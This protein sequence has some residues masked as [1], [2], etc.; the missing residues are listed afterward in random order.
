MKVIHMI[1]AGK[2]IARIEDGT[3]IRLVEPVGICP[4]N[5]GEWYNA[6]FYDIPHSDSFEERW[7][8][9]RNR[10]YFCYLKPELKL[11]AETV[12]KNPTPIMTETDADS[13]LDPLNE[14][15]HQIIRRLS[16]DK[17]ADDGLLVFTI[18]TDGA[19]EFTRI[20]KEISGEKK[21]VKLIDWDKDRYTANSSDIVK[22]SV[23]WD[24]E[25]Y[26]TECPYKFNILGNPFGKMERHREN[27][28]ATRLRSQFVIPSSPIFDDVVL[29]E[30]DENGEYCDLQE[31]VIIMLH[32]MCVKLSKSGGSQEN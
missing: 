2:E 11:I 8:L 13:N 26:W 18:S 16:I 25:D 22:M 17:K 32:N 27:S 30:T 23:D 6:C 4:P 7:L 14:S 1:L 21:I 28:L 10:N 20:N 31:E 9:V 24:A 5:F 29:C 3:F 12:G 15:M 19:Y